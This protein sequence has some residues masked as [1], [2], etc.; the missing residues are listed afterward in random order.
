MKILAMLG[1][2]AGGL[3]LTGCGTPAYSPQERDALILRN[4]NYEGGQLVDDFDHEVIMSRPASSLTAWA[5][6]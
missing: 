5:V 1:L 6:Q 2:L 4:Y 3:L